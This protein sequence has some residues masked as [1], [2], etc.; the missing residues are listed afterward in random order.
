VAEAQPLWQVGA[1][2]LMDG[3]FHRNGRMELAAARVHVGIDPL[4]E[5][6]MCPV[7]A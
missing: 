6:A 4:F 1:D 3:V 7:V 5:Q 2:R